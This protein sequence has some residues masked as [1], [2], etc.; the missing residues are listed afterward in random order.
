MIEDT[1]SA[2]MIITYHEAACIRVG[3]G[4]TTLVFGPVSKKSKEYKPTNF[5]ADI[6]CISF[7]HPDMNG[8]DE[9][10]RGD[11]TP[12]LIYGPGEY[13][14]LNVT[15]S[16][17]VAR[18]SWGGEEKINTVYVVSFDGLSLL[19]L[20]ALGKAELPKEALAMDPPDILIIPVGGAGALSPSEA[21]KLCVNLEP[22]I[23]VPILHDEKTLKQFLKEA[24][25]EGAPREEKLTLKPKDVIGKEGD[26]VVLTT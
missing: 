24:G 4:D 9:A 5:G 22:K 2:R 3:A 19:Y 8:A 14:V 21:H 13:E 25:E 11:K 7:N 23:I 17:F 15:V 6:A 12:F 1:T 10:K 20:G 26:V 18:S 16:G